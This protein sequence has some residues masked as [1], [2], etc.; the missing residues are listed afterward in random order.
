MDDLANAGLWPNEGTGSAGAVRTPVT[1]AV[2]QLLG[3]G[4]RSAPRSFLGPSPPSDQRGAVRVLRRH[5]PGL[6]FFKVVFKQMFW[7]WFSL[8]QELC[9]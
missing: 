6:W 5:C 8:Y 7:E 3:C 4:R 9:L 1:G 2:L